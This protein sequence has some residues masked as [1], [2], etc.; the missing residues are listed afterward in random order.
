MQDLRHGS[1]L[2]MISYPDEAG[3][4][5]CVSFRRLSTACPAHKR[6]MNAIIAPAV[7]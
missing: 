5:S 2:T 7:S 3:R 1:I 4:R 6:K